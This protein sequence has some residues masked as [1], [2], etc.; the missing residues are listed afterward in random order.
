[1]G[2]CSEDQAKAFLAATPA[3]ERMLVQDGIILVKYW[4]AC[5]QARQE[6]RFAERVADPLKR[7]K[8]SPID[9][10]AREKY[11]AY[12]KAREEMLRATHTKQAPWTLVDFNNQR[13]GRLTLIRDLLDRL[14]DKK[15]PPSAVQFPPLAG[16]PKRERFGVLKPIKP[17]AITPSG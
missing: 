11:E 10:Q 1:M 8:L 15:L 13:L 14:P 2:F 6:E 7:W 5:D 16:R 12:T 9:L 17:L 4:L 3:F